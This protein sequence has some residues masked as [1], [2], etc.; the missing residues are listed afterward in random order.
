[1]FQLLFFYLFLRSGAAYKIFMPQIV[2]GEQKRNLIVKHF[3][4]SIYIFSW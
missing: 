3:I 1:M 2:K 4:E